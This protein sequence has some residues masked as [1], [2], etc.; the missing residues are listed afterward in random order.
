MLNKIF[1]ERENTMKNDLF[2]LPDSLYDF[3]QISDFHGVIEDLANL[4]ED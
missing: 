1:N 4:A 3:A 2:D